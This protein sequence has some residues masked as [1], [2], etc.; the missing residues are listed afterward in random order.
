MPRPDPRRRNQPQQR[1][2]LADAA[3]L[4]ALLAGPQPT[5][6]PRPPLM[7][8]LPWEAI[9]HR[10]RAAMRPWWFIGAL[11]VTGA[12]AHLAHAPMETAGIA[13]VGALGVWV[14]ARRKTRG[15]PETAA[16][17]TRAALY[18]ATAAAAWLTAAAAT[19]G[20]TWKLTASTLVPAGALAAA[21]W[22]RYIR[23]QPIT[24]DM[25]TPIDDAQS[26]VARTW[27]IQLS[28]RRGDVVG[29]D[30][31][32]QPIKATTDGRAAGVAL[33]DW[34]RIEGGWAATMT[35]HIGAG[36]DFTSPQLRRAI[37]Q[38]YR[39]G[40]SAIN[41]AVDSDD[42]SRAEL[43]VQPRS[44]LAK[45]QRW[46][47]PAAIDVAAGTAI[48]GRRID[49]NPLVQTLF[50]PN[51]GAPS[52]L[53]L[54]TTGSG[55]TQHIKVDM[56]NELFT[57]VPNPDGSM[58]GLFVSLLHD[59]KRGKDYSEFLDVIAGFG[60]S[61]E[62]AHLLIDALTREMDRRYDMLCTLPWTDDK[63]RARRGGRDWDPL[64]HG[65]ILSLVLDEFHRLAD[66]RALVPKLETL[67]RLIRGCGIRITM[68]THMA[69]I[70]DTGSQAI[71]DMLAG[72]STYLFRTTS[73][74]N[75]ALTNGTRMADVDPRTLEKIPGL[76]YVINGDEAPMKARSAFLPAD[77]I[78]DLLHDDGNRPLG[79]PA[80]I[81]AE[82]LEAFGLEFADW[83]RARA[84]GVAWAPGR[85]AAPAPRPDESLAATAVLAVVMAAEG[86][87]RFND[88]VERSGFS[89]STCSKVLKEL[90]AA[91]L[92]AKDGRGSY[93]A[94]PQ[95]E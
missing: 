70:G 75:A 86:P 47:G 74:L 15:K 5:A 51:W 62:E 28:Y 59:S 37:A 77:D 80:V 71:R 7:P 58:R 12:A 66:D 23:Q 95:G 33:S 18:T 84:A 52:K 76:C 61:R 88:V 60:S 85:A 36:F 16:R 6:P 39:V 78:Y 38:A 29:Q 9:R 63:G 54:G 56:L 10:V 69:T 1:A 20:T 55:K 72:G 22:W 3:A 83:Q 2:A 82:T 49:G 19:D 35:A 94:E 67:S 21:P 57:A 44:Q 26:A 8:A 34:R 46:L 30:E 45:E 90:V 11:G 53:V 27:R 50:V 4:A 87:I 24:I 64:I 91:G 73:A 14:I 79:Y 68:A 17:R 93:R 13:T 32:G 25:P 40:E 48:V 43:L 89:T 31:I 81:P 92:L 41:I 42:A 65:P